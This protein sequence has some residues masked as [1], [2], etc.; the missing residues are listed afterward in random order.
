MSINPSPLKYFA[1]ARKST[2]GEERQALSI[3]S[4][5][6]KIKELFGDLHIVELLEERHSAFTPY[7][8]PVFD[9]MMERIKKGEAQG[10]ITWHPDRLSRNEI[11]A[12]TITYMLRTGH[13]K[14]LKFGSYTF[15]NSPEGIWMLQMALSQSQYSSAKLGKDVKR[16]LEKKVKMGQRPGVANIGYLNSKTELRGQ[17]YILTDP[18]RFP[19]LRKAWD[20]MLTG[21]YTPPKILEILNNEWGYRSPKGN[22]LSKSGIYKMFTSCWYYGFFKYNDIESPGA[23]EPMVTLE[24]FDCVQVLLGRKGKPRNRKHNH[25]FTGIIRCGECNC[26]ITAE[27]KVKFVKRDAQTKSYTYYHCTRRRSDYDCSQRA[28][29]TDIEL[30][31]QIEAEIEKFT[32]LP[33]FLTW[34]LEALNATNDKEVA[35]RGTIHEMQSKALLDV[36]NNLDRLTKLLYRGIIS[37]EEYLKEKP[38]LQKQITQLQEQ[39]G[40]TEVRAEKWLELSEKAFHFATYARHNFVT[41]DSQ[42]KRE[43]LSAMGQNFS[44]K[45]GKLSI[46]ANEWLQPLINGY[47]TVEEDYRALEPAEVCSTTGESRPLQAVRTRWRGHKDSNPENP[48][49]RR[50]VY[51]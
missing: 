13:L 47:K 50:A 32:I 10:I 29:I 3:D 20:L 9:A 39:R 21:T 4:Q 11:D 41:G 24:E 51:H 46:E 36:Q 23:H 5:K 18:L 38:I 34:A 30:E 37:E 17:N 6:D 22:P 42:A 49:W 14:D 35:D 28:G 44:L 2:E 15:D 16:G 1:Y 48:L 25:A 40:D 19:L 7:N 33:E 12:A 43:I 8:R 45:D 31:Q 26:L 27:T